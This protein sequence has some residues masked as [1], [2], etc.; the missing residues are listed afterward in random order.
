MAVQG[1]KVAVGYQ[2]SGQWATGGRVVIS[3]DGGTTWG[4][5]IAI[6]P[7]ATEDHFMPVPAFDAEGHPWVAVKWGDAPALDALIARIVG[8]AVGMATFGTRC[9]AR[10]VQGRERPCGSR[11]GGRDQ[12]VG[13]ARLP[14][15]TLPASAT[16][17]DGH[18]PK[19]ALTDATIG[20]C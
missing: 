6:A 20:R 7:N 16:T 4:E 9:A 2:I 11:G 3:E 5:P 12:T 15:L 1:N 13:A 17:G 14:W 10:V 19:G 8:F 18:L